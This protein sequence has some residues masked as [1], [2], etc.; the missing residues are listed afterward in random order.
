LD[1]YNGHGLFTSHFLEGLAGA[2]DTNKDGHIRSGELFAY[3]AQ[4]V[5]Q[6]ARSK[7][8]KAQTPQVAHEGEGDFFF[9]A[10]PAE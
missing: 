6:I 9:R 5:G 2:A 3:V 1:D 10:I 7:Y 8:G 4:H